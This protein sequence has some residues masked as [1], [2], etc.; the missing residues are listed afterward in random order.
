MVELIADHKLDAVTFTSP[1]PVAA[2]MDIAAVVGRRDDV[3]A[4]LQADVVASCVGP[5]TA[6]AFDMSVAPHLP[7]ERPRTAPIIHQPD[8][9]PPLHRT[10]T[11]TAVVGTPLLLPRHVW[12][13]T[14]GT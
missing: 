14:S 7:P 8:S 12:P 1:P 13:T 2:L 11:A 3:V 9:Q 10:A 6:A 5:L 4:A